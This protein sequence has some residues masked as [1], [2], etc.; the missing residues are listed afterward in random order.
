MGC[1]RLRTDDSPLTRRFA[2][3]SGRALLA[4][5][6]FATARACSYEGERDLF[7]DE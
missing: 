6:H 7:S 4:Q 5:V 2:R 3:P 1:L